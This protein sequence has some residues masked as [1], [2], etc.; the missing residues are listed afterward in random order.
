MALVVSDILNSVR[1]ELLDAGVQQTWTD[2]T[3]IRWL[4]DILAAAV[5]LKRDIAP[6]IVPIPLATGSV[7]LLQAPNVQFMAAYFNTASGVAINHSGLVLLGRYNPTWRATA[8]TT[9]VTDVQADE[10]SPL[11]FHCF[12]PN[13]GTGNLTGLCGT[14]P[15]VTVVTSPIVVPHRQ[16]AGAVADVRGADH[17]CEDGAEGNH[18]RPGRPHR[19][20]RLTCRPAPSP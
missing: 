2:P 6:A 11:V 15:V 4:N 3:L 9:D 14:L 1:D 19:G 20:R 13:N 12:P 16:D 10:R 5:T 8:P 18:V 7:Q 17:R